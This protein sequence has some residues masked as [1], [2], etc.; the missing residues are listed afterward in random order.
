MWSL[1]ASAPALLL[2]VLGIVGRTQITTWE[3]EAYTQ[4]QNRE[5][6]AYRKPVLQAWSLTDFQELSPEHLDRLREVSD[7][8]LSL[9]AEGVLRDVLPGC[10][11][12]QGSDGT[13]LQIIEARQILL[14][15]TNHLASE[16]RRSGDLAGSALSAARAVALADVFKYS[17][18][19]ALQ[20]S[21]LAQASGIRSLMH[22]APRLSKEDLSKVIPYLRLAYRPDEPILPLAEEISHLSIKHRMKLGKSLTDMNSVFLVSHL[23]Q[24]AEG[25]VR[26]QSPL[27]GS[28]VTCGLEVPMANTMMSALRTEARVQ[29]MMAEFLR[30]YDSL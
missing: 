26:Q 13:K 14:N 21:S 20:Q 3:F 4:Q 2:G 11:E 18:I 6:L 22:S 19:S 12:D 27:S 16:Q 1:M 30:T 7:L 5:I 28:S 9:K 24:L 15:Q 25:P 23:D 29:A 10:L 17:G 8:W